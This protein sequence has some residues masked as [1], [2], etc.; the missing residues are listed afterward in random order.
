MFSQDFFEEKA[1]IFS[2]EQILFSKILT[3]SPV[4]TETSVNPT[5]QPVR[6]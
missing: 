3:N 5:E 2:K 6:H 1:F 4:L